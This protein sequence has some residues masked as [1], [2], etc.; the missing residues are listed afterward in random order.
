MEF[1]RLL[2]QQYKEKIQQSNLWQLVV[3]EECNNKSFDKLFK[4]LL[5]KGLVTLGLYR[6]KG[7]NDNLYEYVYTNPTSKT[8]VTQRDRVFVLGKDIPKE[9]IVDH[10]ENL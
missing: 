6:M 7:A 5:D 4:F 8:P 1:E 9:L 3:P 10:K 2:E